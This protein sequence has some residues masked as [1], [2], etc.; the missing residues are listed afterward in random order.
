MEWTCELLSQRFCF[1]FSSRLQ[2]RTGDVIDPCATI[3]TTTLKPTAATLLV[4]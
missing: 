2:R 4:M 3:I 1:A